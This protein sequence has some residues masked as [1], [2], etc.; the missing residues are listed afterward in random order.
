MTDLR[1]Y[2][3]K[4]LGGLGDIRNIKKLVFEIVIETISPSCIYDHD[5]G[6]T[7]FSKP[8]LD[9]RGRINTIFFAIHFYSTTIEEL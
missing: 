7:D 1:I 8:I 4:S 6:S 9:D 3:E 5:I 2:Y